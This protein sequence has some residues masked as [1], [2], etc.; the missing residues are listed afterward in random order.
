MEALFQV[1]DNE[2]QNISR[3]SP[4]EGA[5]GVGDV[6]HMTITVRTTDEDD[7]QA[8]Q[9]VVVI[10]VSEKGVEKYQ[11]KSDSLEEQ[12][13]KLVYT[14]QTYDQF[15]PN[16]I[17]YGTFKPRSF[18]SRQEVVDKLIQR[19]ACPS[20]AAG[21]AGRKRK[22]PSKLGKHICPYCG[23]GCAKPSVLQ[24]HIR[25]HTG[26]R[27]FPCA[28]C[29]FSFKTKSNLY[30]HCKSRAHALKAGL[31]SNLQNVSKDATAEDGGGED[32]AV[33]SDDTGSE[34]ELVESDMDT[35]GAQEKMEEQQTYVSLIPDGSVGQEVS[36]ET[37]DQQYAI[38]DTNSDKI[39]LLQTNE[40]TPY[41]IADAKTAGTELHVPVFLPQLDSPEVVKIGE[42]PVLYQQESLRQA[43]VPLS[44]PNVMYTATPGFEANGG[45]SDKSR[46]SLDRKAI[47][48][49]YLIALPKSATTVV[50]SLPEN[51]ASQ[52]SSPSVALNNVH[53]DI[54]EPP[55][56]STSAE[57]IC[58][59]HPNCEPLVATKA[60]REL[61]EIS[62]RVASATNEGAVIPTAVRMMPDKSVCVTVQMPTGTNKN[63]QT[64]PSE[65]VTKSSVLCEENGKHDKPAS[66]NIKQGSGTG[67][68]VTLPLA[69]Q[70]SLVANQSSAHDILS[71]PKP[72]SVDPKNLTNEMLKERIQQLISE[73]AAIV[74]TPMADPPRHKR[75]SRQNSEVNVLSTKQEFSTVPHTVASTKS[76]T[77]NQSVDSSVTSTV[78]DE[79]LEQG[80]NVKYS[81]PTTSQP[82]PQTLRQGSL[83]ETL[84]KSSG[85][86]ITSSGKA[87]SRSVAKVKATTS[88]QEIKIQ[89]RLAKDSNSLSTVSCTTTVATP[90]MIGQPGVQF[91]GDL[92][93]NAGILTDKVSVISSPQTIGPNEGSIIKNLLAKGPIMPPALVARSS[94]LDLGRPMSSAES[95]LKNGQVGDSTHGPEQYGPFECDECS[96]SFKMAQTLSLHKLCYCRHLSISQKPNSDSAEKPALEESVLREEIIAKY[97]PPNGNVSEDGAAVA[98]KDTKDPHRTL[99]RKL[100][101]SLS[102]DT[103]KEN[104]CHMEKPNID[105]VAK[106]KVGNPMSVPLTSASMP[107][108]LASLQEKTHGAGPSATQMDT[109]KI[110]QPMVSVKSRE[111]GKGLRLNTAIAAAAAAASSPIMTPMSTSGTPQTPQTPGTPNSSTCLLK[112]KLK[113]KLLMK[114]SMSVERML[115]QQERGKTSPVKAGLTSPWH[116]DSG[117]TPSG[118]VT[119]PTQSGDKYSEDKRSPLKKRR[120][121]E[122]GLLNALDKRPLLLRTESAPCVPI[123]DSGDASDLLFRESSSGGRQ[124]TEKGDSGAMDDDGDVRAGMGLGIDRESVCVPVVKAQPVINPVQLSS[125]LLRPLNKAPLCGIIAS[126]ISLEPFPGFCITLPS[127]SGPATVGPTAYHVPMKVNNL[128]SWFGKSIVPGSPAKIPVLKT[129]VSPKGSVGMISVSDISLDQAT[130]VQTAVT[131]SNSTTAAI[132]IT[133]TSTSPTIALP[134]TQEKPVTPLYLYGHSFPSL[135]GSTHTTYC[136]IQRL[137]PMYVRQGTNKKISMYSN[138]RVAPQNSNPFGL[139]PKMLLNLYASRYTSNPVYK[140][141]VSP[142]FSSGIL[143]HSTYWDFYSRHGNKEKTNV[144][145]TSLFHTIIDSGVGRN[146]E[147]VTVENDDNNESNSAESKDAEKVQVVQGGFKS[148][149][150]YTYIRGRGRGK[151][152]CEECGIR[153]KKPSMLKKHIRTHT[154]FRPYYCKHCNFS[155]KTKG[156]LTKHMKSKAHLKKCLELGILP[157]PTTVDDSQIDEDALAR[158]T[159]ISKKA[160]ILED[161]NSSL[162]GDEDEDEEEHNEDEDHEEEV[163][164]IVIETTQDR[165]KEADHLVNPELDQKGHLEGTSQMMTK[166]NL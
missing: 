12:G 111:H 143:T 45:Q 25:A 24:K 65:T 126:T 130:E 82:F 64:E 68:V 153:C 160:K 59:P 157:V 158:Q 165:G 55:Q 6:D 52:K 3:V 74:D 19:A 20:E 112:L 136:C 99:K 137:Q 142:E 161:D 124:V 104:L 149:E 84:I 120:L 121:K 105:S 78:K 16:P 85:T 41:Q 155:F 86:D 148:N 71:G 58:L 54:M 163:E 150:D 60:L 2:L 89:I 146:E 23:R 87:V 94:S 135:R 30:K 35:S 166:E 77:S 51:L 83:S 107:V 131:A 17:S 145:Q 147:T 37:N 22:H 43:E 129:P 28:A 33:E 138:W 69:S 49:T 39:I 63:Q 133:P 119:R 101:R 156:N 29:G 132:E 44:A 134:C 139:T 80:D 92:D 47:V 108:L 48:K 18:K 154:D 36:I 81:K 56:A 42:P 31:A 7:E 152:V 5:L 123:G 79:L 125:V 98:K 46:N 95:E 114:R 109:V 13:L 96:V 110:G 162:G 113:G 11:L 141:S 57:T 61:E 115:S 97:F 50:P 73:N 140:E 66:L 4:S 21:N 72:L 91:P 67:L 151:F 9:R 118:A 103:V 102:K 40:Q 32:V 164:G 8:T 100:S 128:S 10:P 117:L 53:E 15:E 106:S 70:G 88:S 116:V 122:G 75:L 127:I 34:A 1:T 90:P 38:L 159:A 144:G 62:G 26:E 93:R 27:P 14:K 76:Q